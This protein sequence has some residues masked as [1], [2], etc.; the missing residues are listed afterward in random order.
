MEENETATSLEEH[1]REMELTIRCYRT[2]IAREVHAEELVEQCMTSNPFAFSATLADEDTMYLNQAKKEPDWK[3]FHEAMIKEIKDH[4]DGK[5][6]EVV[7]RDSMPKGHRAMRG[8]WSMKRKRRVG[9]GEVYKW[10]ARLCIDGSSQEKG[11]N[12]WETYS[13]VVGWETIRSLLTLAI[14]NKW[15]TRQIDFVLAFPQAEVEC[16][17]YMEIP[18]ECY[19]DGSEFN[20]KNVLL[21]KKNLYGT[22]QASRVWFEFLKEGLLDIGFEQSNEDK[23][24]F[25][26]GETIF[27]VYVDDGI[28]MGPNGQE[29]ADV[30]RTLGEKYK[31]TDEGDLNEYLGIKMKRTKDGR[32][33]T[34]PALIQ[35]ILQTVGVA[36]DRGDRQEVKTPATKTLHKDEGGEKRR[37]DWDYRSVVG[38]LNWLARSTRP[39]LIFAVS[40]VGRFMAFPKKS[41]EDAIMRI[42]TYLRDT[43]DKGMIMKPNKKKG[44]EV[45]A[46][47]DF[48]GGYNKHNAED[49]ATAKSRTCYHIMFN[50]CLVYSHSKLQTEIALSTTEAEYICLSQA[51]RTVI[52][53]MRFFQELAKKIKSFKYKRPV[54]KCK[55]F[56]DNNGAIAIATTENL[57]PRTKHIN[58]KYHH[59]KR[60]V[61]KGYVTIERIDTKDQLADIGTKALLPHVFVPLRKALIGW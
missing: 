27:I 61:R 52:S 16:P 44:F 18:K 26:K 9:T 43:R 8:V 17:M 50:N 36:L 35:R 33:L 51:L 11:V 29:I 53:L 2:E 25:Y 24:V 30:I 46:D 55:A 12:Y 40:Q 57:R 49:P 22:K 28:L 10:K 14:I 39:E 3:Q 13:P 1:R 37:L 42:C 34:Q 47:A 60:Y 59:F 58:I 48:A 7:P 20:E 38:M 41:H 45:Y 32:E 5:H 23:A 54:F 19:V 56:E 4:T 31:L 6:W 15:T 21:L